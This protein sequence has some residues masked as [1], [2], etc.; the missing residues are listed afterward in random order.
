VQWW[1]SEEFSRGRF[2]FQS[3][4]SRE[5]VII[6]DA[7]EVVGG[8]ELEVRERDEIQT[9]LDFADEMRR[10]VLMSSS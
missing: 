7:G 9:Y 5:H 4:V 8:D 6:L 1:Y 2:A 3:K 10:S